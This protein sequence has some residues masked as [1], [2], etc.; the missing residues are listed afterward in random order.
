MTTATPDSAAMTA[1]EA[2]NAAIEAAHAAGEA[3]LVSEALLALVDLDPALPISARNSAKSIRGLAMHAG[4]CIVTRAYA[5]DPDGLTAR[6]LALRARLDG[7]AE[8]NDA[9]ASR[10]A[11]VIEFI[12]RVLAKVRGDAASAGL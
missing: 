8:G 5:L 10:A 7:V 3:M 4:Q 11:C 2:I 9:T 1:A 6:A 12:D